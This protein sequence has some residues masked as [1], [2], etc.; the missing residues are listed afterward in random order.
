MRYRQKLFLALL[1]S[2]GAVVVAA[3]FQAL[4]LWPG[5]GQA[6]AGDLR[7]SFLDVG[8]GDAILI[9]TPDNRRLLIDGGEDGAQLQSALNQ[10][11]GWFDKR[12]DWVLLTH[13]HSDHLKGLNSLF[14]G[15]DIKQI[16]AT[17]VVH[18]SSAY[19]AWLQN[20]KKYQ[21]PVKALKAGDE[22]DLGQG[23]S[24]KVL[25]P[26][27]DLAGQSVDDL[28]DSSLV[29][30]LTWGEASALF[31]GDAGE[32]VEKSLLTLNQLAPLDLLKIG[33]HGSVS[34]SGQAFLEAVRPRTAVISVGA[35]NP[36]GHPSARIL[37]RL[38]LLGVT[39]WRTDEQGTISF[40]SDGQGFAPEL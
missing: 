19:T 35:D 23:V 34:A 11:L 38:K 32:E 28:N 37:N 33:H 7:V 30:R 31:M 21:V 29:L 40:R 6:A 24:L 36:F 12:L 17:G 10:E 26:R 27:D 39:I 1:L 9:E 22:I 13:P 14:A 8:Q 4:N 25:W 18:T 2:V 20:I 5:A 3:A 15:Y 16:G